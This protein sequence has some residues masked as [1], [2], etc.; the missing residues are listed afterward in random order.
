MSD[1][2][3]LVKTKQRH[4][5]P[6]HSLYSRESLAC[7]LIPESGP[8]VPECSNRFAHRVLRLKFNYSGCRPMMQRICGPRR[9]L[10]NVRGLNS[11]AEMDV[12]VRYA[13]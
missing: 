5:L 13:Y 1:V 4:S 3:P 7:S 6:I 8:A 2:H 12:R 10:Q 11:P 9:L